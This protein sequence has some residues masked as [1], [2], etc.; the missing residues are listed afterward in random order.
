MKPL[1]FTNKLSFGNRIIKDLKKDGTI[2]GAVI[3]DGKGRVTEKKD[4][5]LCIPS[6]YLYYMHRM[7]YYKEAYEVDGVFLDK[8]ESYKAKAMNIISLRRTDVYTENYYYIEKEYLNLIKYWKYLLEREEITFVFFD[9]IPHEPATYTLY[10]VAQC[11]GIPTL[12]VFPTHFLSVWAVGTSIE[13]IGRNTCREIELIRD[14]K[15]YDIK[16]TE[17][18]KLIDE[19]RAKV[20]S[21]GTNNLYSSSV[22]KKMVKEAQKFTKERK[23]KYPFYRVAGDVLKRHTLDAHNVRVLRDSIQCRL[24]SRSTRYYNRMSSDINTSEEY[25]YFALQQFPEATTLPFAGAYSNHMV[26]IRLMA[27]A[28]ND[29]GIKL[30]VKEHW[31]Q[32]DRLKDFYDE[33]SSLP[34]VRIISS[35]VDSTVV[36]K[37]AFATATQTGS[38]ISESVVRHKPAFAFV[39]GWWNGLKSVF[40]VNTA[41]EIKRAVEEIRNGNISYEAEEEIYF[42]AVEHTNIRWAIAE[43]ALFG[44]T[45]EEIYKDAKELVK[46]YIRGGMSEEWYY[47][48]ES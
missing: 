19:Y 33:L 28:L 26:A 5:F 41:Q 31:T 44:L 30:Y 8:I 34:N 3:I 6:Q 37:N 23:L 27:Q 24:E 39:D 43:N 12:I 45:E 40:V 20:S 46:Q 11:L 25:V 17:I 22:K 9:N 32:Y 48:R 42:K 7:P 29:C 14:G 16:E 47:V 35:E 21:S 10:S 38:V 15:T 1:F 4:S 2:S 13:G 18:K 36:M